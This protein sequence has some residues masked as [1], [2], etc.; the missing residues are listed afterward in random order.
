MKKRRKTPQKTV[1]VT[2]K[3]DLACGQTKAEGWVG[4]DRVPTACVDVVHDL[5]RFPWP[6]K[7]ESVAE[8]RCSHFVEHIPMAETPQGVDL[9]I[10]FMNELHRV[11]VPGGKATII[12]P[13]YASVRA[14]QDPTHRRAISDA[15]FLY[16]NRAWREREKLD[17]YPVTTDF[18]FVP[19][20]TMDAAVAAR[21][22]ETRAFWMTRYL[23]V[24]SD[25]T[26]VLTKRKPEGAP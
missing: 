14:W 20:Y 10:A 22:E 21:N 5:L 6:F 15:T 24:I 17:H 8:A 16:F 2:V 7:D 23:N 4:V 13:W 1:P 9:L 12:A 25:L 18:D 11:L 19:S 3:L 26:V